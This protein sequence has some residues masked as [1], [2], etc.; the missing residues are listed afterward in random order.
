M[1][2]REVAVAARHP[3]MSVD[4]KWPREAVIL[5][6]PTCRVRGVLH[7]LMPSQAVSLV[8]GVASPDA[9]GRTTAARK[10]GSENCRKDPGSIVRRVTGGFCHREVGARALLCV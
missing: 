7:F 3:T 8:L 5:L 1:R 9:N 2:D 6:L 4:I 10:A